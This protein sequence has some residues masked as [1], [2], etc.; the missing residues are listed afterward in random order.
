MRLAQEATELAEANR[1]LGP[2]WL[3]LE[4]AAL[5]IGIAC[6]TLPFGHIPCGTAQQLVSSAQ[7]ICR[8]RDI[9]GL[10]LWVNKGLGSC[11]RGFAWQLALWLA[12]DALA[13]PT[14]ASRRLV[15][16]RWR[17]LCN[18]RCGRF[19]WHRL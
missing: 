8:W 4:D 3:D 6:G 11:F 9:S 14:F 17:W 1:C 10:R 5:H 19:I 15:C 7:T 18:H 13:R 16:W 2:R 12:L